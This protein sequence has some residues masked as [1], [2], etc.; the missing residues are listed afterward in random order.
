MTKSVMTRWILILLSKAKA[1]TSSQALATFVAR[2]ATS[3][4]S[5]GEETEF[6]TKVRVEI[7]MRM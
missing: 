3:P 5:V 7:R 2:S 6:Q 4:Q 1:R